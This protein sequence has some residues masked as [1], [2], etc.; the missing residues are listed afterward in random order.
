MFLD[1]ALSSNTGDA[2]DA[3]RFRFH[4]IGDDGRRRERRERARIRVGVDWR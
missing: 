2:H 1:T 3:P 4:Q